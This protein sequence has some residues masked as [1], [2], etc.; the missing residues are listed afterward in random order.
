MGMEILEAKLA[1]LLR[2]ERRKRH[3]QTLAAASCYAVALAIVFL[4]LH[5][6][7]PGVWL[8]WS[9]PA[10]WLAALAPWFFYRARWREM[11]SARVLTRLD[12]TLKL[13]ELTVTA[14]E[15][16]RR[17]GSGAASLFVLKRAQEKLRAIDERAL[18][19]RRWSWP[20]YA[21]AP[22]FVLWFA[23]LW[24][25]FDR[26]NVDPT[27][28]SGL[29]TLAH[30]LRDFSRE[31]QDKAKNQ[32]LRDTLALSRELE[33]TAQKNIEANTADDAFKK[34]L[35]GAAK[36]F[37]AAAKASGEKNSFSTAESE[38][39]LNELKAE[40]D[41]MRDLV[42]LPDGS[43]GTQELGQRWVERLAAMPQL[44][45]QFDKIP[46]EGGRPG[47]NELKSFL[48]KLEQQVTGELDRRSLIDAQQYLEQMM[49][50][51]Q[52]ERGENAARA[53][54]EQDSD[55]EGARDKTHSDLPGKQPGRRDEENRSLPE[56]RAAA[57]TQVKG[58]LGEGGS[59]AFMLKGNPTAGKSGLSQEEVVASYRRQAE[60]DLN[61]ERVPEGLKETIKNYFLSLG[62]AKK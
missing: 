7:L 56:F 58:L 47:E 33:K 52:G 30:K 50:Q 41:A 31:L 62:E 46:R 57:P 39:S 38:R 9:I 24:L 16:S 35:A 28:Q 11:D 27:R 40:L 14:W 37:E 32:G 23:L 48:D 26:Q 15:V 2:W 4:P 36:K 10:V 61:S 17:G 53:K 13:D 20:A 21:A 19:P 55:T 42:Q 25:D 6:Y 5:V 54:G 22:L 60:Q 18:L 43:K 1:D 49:K 12:H 34:E 45:Q 8:R 44:K 51:G 29:P 3:E 59:S